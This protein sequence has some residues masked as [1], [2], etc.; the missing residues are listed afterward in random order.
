[1]PRAAPSVKEAVYHPDTGKK[2][3]VAFT[4]ASFVPANIP[5]CAGMLLMPP[6]PFNA[7]FWQWV[8]QSYN[9]GFNYVNRNAAGEE[10][11][12]DDSEALQGVLKSYAAATT[13]ACGM[14]YGLNKVVAN[15][16]TMSPA[17]RQLVTRTV[18]FLA[19][20]TAGA[21][22]ALLMRYKEAIDG[23]EVVD[24]EGTKHGKSVTAGRLGL[25]QVA[26]SRVFLPLP[27]LLLPP[28]ILQF[29]YA[30][31]FVI[32]RPRIK[33]LVE[34]SVITLSLAGFFPCAIG[35]FPQT[36]S[37]AATTLEPKFQALKDTS[38]API[39][40]FYFNKGV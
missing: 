13:V 39:T 8:N 37:V 5:I 28:Y 26:A 34:L 23:V 3:N 22:N 15:A 16:T 11:G 18:P 29:L 17:V 31:Q 40:T 24:A 32:N 38:G 1:M 12:A 7:M 30:R 14:A 4:M 33:P 6:T 9:A 20:A 36:A 19:V 25:A 27:I 35:L 10:E 2:L 21:A